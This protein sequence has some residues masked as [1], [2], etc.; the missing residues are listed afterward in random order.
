MNEAITNKEGIIISLAIIITTY[1]VVNMEAI[2][3]LF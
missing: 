2:L 1:V 3:I